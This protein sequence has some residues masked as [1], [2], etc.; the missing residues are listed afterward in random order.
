MLFF[1]F[2][3]QSEETLFAVI[4]KVS[5]ENSERVKSGETDAAVAVEIRATTTQRRS[6]RD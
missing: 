4:F 1:F 3:R 2:R 6:T 5:L